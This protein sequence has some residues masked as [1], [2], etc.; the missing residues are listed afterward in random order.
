MSSPVGRLGLFV[1]ALALIAT[2]MGVAHAAPQNVAVMPFYDLSGGKGSIGEAIR[3]TVTHDLKDVP[4]LKV[5]ERSNIDKVLTERNLQGQRADLGANATMTIGKLLG[6]TLIVTGAY[7][8]SGATVR[9]TARFIKVETG[10]IVGTAKVDGGATDFLALQ[11]KVTAQLL[12]SAGIE[13]AQVQRF[14]KR[15]RPKLKSIRVVELYG[16]AMVETDEQRKSEILKEALVEDPSFSY[17]VRDLD[18]LQARM[19][20]Y[21]A[22][23]G[24]AQGE[25]INALRRDAK[26]EADPLK[27]ASAR[28]QLLSAMMT[29]RRYHEL[30]REARAILV[31]AGPSPRKPKGMMVSAEEVAGMWLVQADGSL[32]QTDAV[33]RDGELF[34]K[35]FPASTYYSSVQMLVEQAIQKKR[36]SDEGRRTIDNALAELKSYERWDPCKVGHTYAKHA[37][38]REAQRLYIACIEIG[39]DERGSAY[40]GLLDADMEIGEF[41]AAS[42]HLAEALQPKGDGPYRSSLESYRDRI[43]AD[44]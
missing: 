24:I 30:Q 13:A 42:K 39:T 34:M 21:A 8:R 31:E 25:Q 29:S 27:R 37:M 12:G 18:A 11:D 36:K 9:I 4:G 3:E 41:R 28:M 6:A 26:G 32:H 23:A 33:L 5:V 2:S 43:P 38:W 22:K 10:E 16:D 1:G 7:Q 14:A 15:S 40:Y 19:Q 17:A 20:E 35:R 44:D